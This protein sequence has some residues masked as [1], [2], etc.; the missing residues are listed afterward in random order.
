VE[1]NDA[2]V[3]AVAFTIQH[4]ATSN[5]LLPF[6]PPDR[7][8]PVMAQASCPLHFQVRESGSFVVSANMGRGGQRI[9]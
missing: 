2:D 1:Q 9:L 3:R 4:R 8:E 5:F 6:A 7:Q